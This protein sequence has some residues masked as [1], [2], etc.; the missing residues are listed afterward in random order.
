MWPLCKPAVDSC[1]HRKMD[2]FEACING[3]FS[4]GKKEAPLRATIAEER[5]TPA[6]GL[7][8]FVVFLPCP[9][10]EAMRSGLSEAYFS[11]RLMTSAVPLDCEL[12]EN[13]PTLAPWEWFIAI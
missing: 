5:S 12:S 2:L 6:R 7:R 13:T 11:I 8:T 9:S 4:K 3:G 10:L 1:D